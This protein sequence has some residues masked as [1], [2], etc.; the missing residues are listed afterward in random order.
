MTDKKYRDAETGE[1]VTEGYARENPSTTVAETEKDNVVVI[2]GLDDYQ[3]KAREFA[4]YPN[5]D[6][7]LEYPVLGL[8]GEAGEVANVVKKISRDDNGYV[9]PE[10]HT[11][12]LDELGDTLWYVANIASELDVTLNEVA[13]YNLEKLANRRKE[14][15]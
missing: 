1:Y 5:L 13:G 6:D 10:V 7:N 3:D 11:K 4:F 15:G 9:R 2:T 8:N 14:K 12:L